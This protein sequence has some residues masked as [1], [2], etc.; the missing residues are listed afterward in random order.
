MGHLNQC[1]S[2]VTSGKLKGT[3]NEFY[4]FIK[5]EEMLSSIV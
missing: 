4:E 1:I 3:E 5:M 2:P